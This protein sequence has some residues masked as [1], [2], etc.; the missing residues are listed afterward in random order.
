MICVN[1]DRVFLLSH[2]RKDNDDFKIIGIYSTRINADVALNR[3][4]TKPGFSA[5]EDEFIIDEYPLDRD[6]WFEGFTDL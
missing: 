5:H 2:V 3:L 6:F 1:P 4:K